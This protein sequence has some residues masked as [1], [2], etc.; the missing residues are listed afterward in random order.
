MKI[1]KAKATVMW[2][3]GCT[4]TE[5]SKVFNCTALNVKKWRNLNDMPTNADLFSWDPD[6]YRDTNK[7]MYSKYVI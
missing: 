5:I 3:N 2:W 4:D 6:G 1:D 7:R